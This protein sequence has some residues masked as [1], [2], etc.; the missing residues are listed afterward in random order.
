MSVHDR[1]AEIASRAAQRALADQPPRA[2]RPQAEPSLVTERCLEGVEQGGSFRV[3]DGA[4]VTPLAREEAWRR[5]I[6]LEGDLGA[7]VA[8]TGS[9]HVVA[10][11]A[12]HGGFALKQ[13]LAAW[14]TELGYRPLDL[15]TFDATSCDYPEF[16]RAVALAVTRGQAALGVVVDGAGI[17]S[18]IAANKVTGA[19]AA[20]CWNERSAQNAR[21]HNHANILSIGSGSMTPEEAHRTLRAFLAT[22]VG[23]G[24]HARR[25]G[26]IDAI[27]RETLSTALGQLDAARSGL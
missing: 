13:E 5:R 26:L 17:G 21:E 18:A 25:A 20:T 11:G 23:E 9:E 4:R 24:R 14:L 1:I 16:A 12:D 19:R 22:P 3:P 2:P 15:G 10:L 8:V 6:R 7:P 27:E